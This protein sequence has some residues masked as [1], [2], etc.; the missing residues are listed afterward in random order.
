MQRRT[1]QKMLPKQSVKNK[2][3]LTALVFLLHH[4]PIFIH[5]KKELLINTVQS[6]VV[7]L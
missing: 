7:R 5:I 2:P 1:Q 4:S 6:E 3:G